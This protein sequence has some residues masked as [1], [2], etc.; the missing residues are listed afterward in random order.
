MFKQQVIGKINEVLRLL[1]LQLKGQLDARY[2][3]FEIFACDFLLKEDLSPVLMEITSNPSFSFEME[4]SREFIK[5]LLRDVIT[6]ASDLHESGKT[7][8][9][10][11]FV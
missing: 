10:S 8:A 3:C 6:M 4:D 1:F 9:T 5:T 7:K 11:Q 2:G